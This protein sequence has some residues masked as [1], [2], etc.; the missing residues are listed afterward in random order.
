MNAFNIGVASA[1]IALLE[2]RSFDFLAQL[3]RL[4]HEEAKKL[5]PSNTINLQSCHETM[6]K[7]HVLTEMD[8]ISGVCHLPDI[9][10]S[11]L[12][13]LLDQRL[14]AVGAFFVHKQYILG[15][16]RASMELS[17]YGDMNSQPHVR[18]ISI[19]ALISPLPRFR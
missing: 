2:G 5:S 14:A 4:Q 18:L 16:R 6:L 10:K 9:E 11:K 13:M 1:L 17:K 15:L 19:D 8:I 7:L 12:L 3:G